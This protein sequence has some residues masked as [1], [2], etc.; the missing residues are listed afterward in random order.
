[1]KRAVSR[2]SLAENLQ[3]PKLDGEDPGQL[4]A[5]THGAAA[6]ASQ[7]SAA[8]CSEDADDQVVLRSPKDP[9][10]SH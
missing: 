7:S 4:S 2:G 6:N 10:R 5:G 3:K 9:Q 1:M 8:K